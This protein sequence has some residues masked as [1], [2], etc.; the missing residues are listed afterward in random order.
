MQTHQGQNYVL[1][2]KMSVLRL[3]EVKTLSRV[4]QLI[5]CQ[6][7]DSNPECLISDPIS[8]LVNAIA[9]F[10]HCDDQERKEYLGVRKADDQ[11]YQIIEQ[12][13]MIGK[14]TSNLGR[15][16]SPMAFKDTAMERRGQKTPWWS[17][18]G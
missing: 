1:Y 7:W 16:K 3:R 15:N 6:S 8:F 11:Q 14:N 18:L 13:K 9:F 2:L 12:S 5:L 4:A 10:D 17:K